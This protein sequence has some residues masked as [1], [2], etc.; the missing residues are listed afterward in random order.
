MQESKRIAVVSTLD[1]KG[2]HAAFIKQII[3][4]RGHQPILMDIGVLGQPAMPATVAREEIAQAGG[5]EL[6]A[7]VAAKD[8]GKALAVM[9][10]GLTAVLMKMQRDGLIDA[11]LGM[12]GEQQGTGLR[13]HA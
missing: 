4:A 11:V 3:E 6:H 7:L 2:E 5:A 9:A 13:W 12:G 1:T 10:D 8:R